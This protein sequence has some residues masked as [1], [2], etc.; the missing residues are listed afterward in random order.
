MRRGDEGERAADS[1]GSRTMAA[2]VGRWMQEPTASSI[3]LI[4]CLTDGTTGEKEEDYRRF[5][6]ANIDTIKRDEMFEK[7]SEEVE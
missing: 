1:S 5:D 2:D 4:C 3:G 7:K 6:V